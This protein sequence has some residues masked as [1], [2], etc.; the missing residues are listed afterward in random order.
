MAD[1]LVTCADRAPPPVCSRDDVLGVLRRS[2]WFCQLPPDMQDV[3]LALCQ[4]RRLRRNEVACHAGDRCEGMYF[5]AQGVVRLE[6][7]TAGGEFRTMA[8]KQPGFWFGQEALLR[9]A[10][11]AFTVTC[12]TDVILA[13]LPR[14]EFER[15]AEDGR[16]CRAFAAMA[17][18]QYDESVEL[19]SH[20]LLDEPEQRIMARLTQL[21]RSSMAGAPNVLRITQHELAE[22][23]ALS[24]PTTQ[25]VLSRLAQ[26]GLLRCG[27]RRIE[28]QPGLADD[29]YMDVL[30]GS[31]AV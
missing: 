31:A 11:H 1:R 25:Q 30:P 10:A 28:L 5:L 9:A 13:V 7:P 18:A 12:S 3:L 6:L 21:A 17:L 4:R 26:R 27:Y 14:A 22:M 15:L 24:R 29:R 20:F 2:P 23:C 16:W 8:V 19:L